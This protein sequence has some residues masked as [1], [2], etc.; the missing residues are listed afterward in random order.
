[1]ENSYSEMV[2]LAWR[3]A[4]KDSDEKSEG[5]NDSITAAQHSLSSISLLS[6]FFWRI[7]MVLFSTADLKNWWLEDLNSP[8]E[9]QIYL[10]FFVY[11]F[12]KQ[13]V[14]AIVNKRFLRKTKHSRKRAK[15]PLRSLLQRL[16]CL[17]RHFFGQTV[18][19]RTVR[20]RLHA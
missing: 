3:W 4:V 16:Y 14:V 20:F 1:M 9:F 7:Q 18:A 10:L 17:A 13:T 8:F 6:Q 15:F 2:F 19:S 5:K 11:S 12:F